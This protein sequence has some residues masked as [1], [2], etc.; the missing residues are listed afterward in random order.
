MEN[1]DLIKKLKKEQ[2]K[3]NKKLLKLASFIVNQQDSQTISNYQL[4]LLREQ[5]NAMW[6]YSE[7]LGMHI[8]DLKENA[9][10]D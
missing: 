3:L 1:K 2:V 7:V 6:I 9:N 8:S 10:N 4:K 5:H